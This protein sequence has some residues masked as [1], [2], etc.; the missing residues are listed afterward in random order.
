MEGN[1]R[2]ARIWLDLILKK[3]LKK[4]KNF[5]IINNSFYVYCYICRYLRGSQLLSFWLP[6]VQFITRYR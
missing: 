5:F 4:L 6:K 3:R 1:G 2:S